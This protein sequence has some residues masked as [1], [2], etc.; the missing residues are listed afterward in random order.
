MI[1]DWS[2]YPGSLDVGFFII[3]VN[4]TRISQ[5]EDHDHDHDGERKPLRILQIVNSSES[6]FVINDL[7][8]AMEFAAIV[9]LVGN[10][11]EIYKSENVTVETEESGKLLGRQ[12]LDIFIV[13][14]LKFL[15][16]FLS[17]S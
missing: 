3:S 6:S 8:V 11:N 2:G 1:V 10:D 17:M 4:Q 16:G 5:Y 13:E 9:Y 14:S 12:R 7:P 15:E